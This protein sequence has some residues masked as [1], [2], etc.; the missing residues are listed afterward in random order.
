M[1][2]IFLLH[3]P[4]VHSRVKL[5]IAVIGEASCLMSPSTPSAPQRHGE[6]NCTDS[7]RASHAVAGLGP[8]RPPRHRQ[9]WSASLRAK[10]KLPILMRCR[11]EHTR[12]VWTESCGLHGWVE[13]SISSAPAAT[14]LPVSVTS[15]YIDSNITSVG[16]YAVKGRGL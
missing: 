5:S 2:H 12:D 7:Y 10:C 14:H 3:E 6:Y 11:Y 13:V 15:Y 8:L 4:T 1:T 16:E 9:D